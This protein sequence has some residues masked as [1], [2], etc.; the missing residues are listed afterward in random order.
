M[1]FAEQRNPIGPLSG[2]E[3]MTRAGLRLGIRG[4]SKHAPPVW[5][6]ATAL[7]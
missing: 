5:P 2:R 3:P 7:V 4:F 1:N 6:P